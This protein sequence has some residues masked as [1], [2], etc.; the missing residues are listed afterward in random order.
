MRKY[1]KGIAIALAILFVSIQS[2][3]AYVLFSDMG[4]HW[5]KDYIKW[6]SDENGLIQGYEDGTF[7]PEKAITREEYIIGLNKLLYESKVYDKVDFILYSDVIPYS[8]LEQDSELY[9]SLHEL[10][11]YLKHFRNTNL[12]LEAIFGGS[13]FQPQKP[14]NRYEAALLAR[15]ITTPAI[16][17]QNHQFK[18][19]TAGLPYYKEL[20]ELVGNGIIKGYSDQT[21]RPYRPVTRVEAAVIFSRIN[22][23]IKFQ[24]ADPLVFKSIV[25][26]NTNQQ[27]PVFTLAKGSQGAEGQNR[28]F[29]NAITS[30]EYMS[31]IGYIPHNEAHLY[32]N[33]PID[34]LWGLKNESYD[35]VVG[36]NYYLVIYDKNTGSLRKTELIQEAMEHLR[37]KKNEPVEGLDLFLKEAKKYIS[38]KE[39]LK[40][41]KELNEGT[42]NTDIKL[43]TGIFLAE[44]YYQNKAF[45]L[46]LEAYKALIAMEMPEKTY[47]QLLKNYAYVLQQ[48][49]GTEVAISGLKELNG[50]LSKESGYED[51]E[52][53][54]LVIGLLKKLLSEKG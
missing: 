14:I 9:Y 30:L 50:K 6:A 42:T 46:S 29:K 43:T 12:K 7:K 22:D 53:H 5:G 10:N 23:D 21:L 26:K 48:S 20:M 27:L 52:T 37:S 47:H 19:V 25:I 13:Q 11:I 16:E 33:K 38:I 2:S 40:F 51:S 41:A 1:T 36:N 35:N 4:D 32:D 8:D 31:F 15:A 39:V 17:A 49:G 18:D 54:K 3:F 44:E 45:G 34:T 24:V 28:R